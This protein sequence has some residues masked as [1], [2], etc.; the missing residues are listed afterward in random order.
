MPNEDVTIKAQFENIPTLVSIGVITMPTKTTYTAGEA[1]DLSGMV[2]R[3][4]Y[5]DGSMATVTGW[6]STPANGAVLS[7]TGPNLVTISYTE[8]SVTKTTTFNVTVNP[9]AS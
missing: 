9:A 1:L 3:A 8:G 5:S 7:T 6:T 2:V 4:T